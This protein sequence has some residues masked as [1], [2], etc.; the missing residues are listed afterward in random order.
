[1]KDRILVVDDQCDVAD[2]LVRLLRVLGYEAR[3]TYDGRNAA[4]IAAD[5]LPD[6]AFIDIGMPDFDGYKT[7]SKIRGRRECAHA[8][9][10]AFTGLADLEAKQRAYEAGF[11]LHVAK[12]VNIDKLEEVL[13]LLN[14]KASNQSTANNLSRATELTQA[15]SA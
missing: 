10:I 2:A 14:P 6:M 9:L 12:P 5:F 15:K 7:V 8:I 3:A 4:D 1:M 11:D 13:S